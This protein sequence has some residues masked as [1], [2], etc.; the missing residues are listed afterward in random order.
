MITLITG[1]PGAGKTLYCVAQILTEYKDRPLFTDGIPDLKREHFE[2]DQPI[3]SDS[4]NHICYDDWLP[5]NGV[6][7]VDECQRVWRPRGPS[8]KVPRG[9]EAME[10]HRHKGHDLVLI[11][12]H[13]NLLDANVRR[14]VGR[15]IHVRR[16]FGWNRAI[17]YE[18]DAATDPTRVSIAIRRSWKYPKSVFDLYKSA[19]VHTKRGNRIPLPVVFFGLA[20]LAAPAVWYFAIDRTAGKWMPESDAAKAATE[21]A[22]AQARGSTQP[23]VLTAVPAKLMEAMQ[24]VDVHNPLSAP[25]YA[26]SLPPVV[27]PEIKG[28]IA[29]KSACHCYTQQN[30]SIWLPDEQCRNRAAG[31]YYDP[32]LNPNHA[33][34]RK[35][36]TRQASNPAD[37]SRSPEGD[38]PPSGAGI[39]VGPGDY[40]GG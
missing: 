20:A 22:T 13:P 25:I 36:P 24:P 37:A 8:A 32:Y 14:L 35:A 30:T 5:E 9:V 31:K 29:S 1:T 4:K 40:I 39:S 19:S 12:Q 38:A 21:P 28:C 11:T 26:E 15:H 16:M 18:W 33:D 34:E 3:E 17:V 10:K 27:P 6:L 7:V 2:V 23:V